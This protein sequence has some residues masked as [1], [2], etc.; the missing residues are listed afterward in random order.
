MHLMLHASCGLT[1]HD[2]GP[3][4]EVDM[5]AAIKDMIREACKGTAGC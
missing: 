5:D 1:V 2:E 4:H 3:G